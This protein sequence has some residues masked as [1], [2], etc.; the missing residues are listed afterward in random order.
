M[1]IQLA[2]FLFAAGGVYAKL[3][4]MEKKIDKMDGHGERI[5]KVETD[6]AN[7]KQQL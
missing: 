5:A 7:I 4:T 3:M 2:T 1:I 6:I